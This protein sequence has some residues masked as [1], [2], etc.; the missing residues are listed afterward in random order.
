MHGGGV[1]LL[2]AAAPQL[3]CVEGRT[4]V[5]PGELLKVHGGNGLFSLLRLLSANAWYL[6]L[7]LITQALKCTDWPVHGSVDV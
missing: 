4:T 6:S 3:Q 2:A 7:G 1:D 5:P